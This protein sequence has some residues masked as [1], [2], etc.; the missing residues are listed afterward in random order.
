MRKN[1]GK[2]TYFYPL[3]VLIIG[4]YDKDGNPDAMNAAWGGIHD[5]DEIFICL[6]SDHKTTKNIHLKQEF[7]VSFADAKHV[8][9]AD[10][11]GMVSAN[12]VVD[13]VAKAKLHP[14]KSEF[15]DAPYFEEFPMSLDC[16][17]KRL[18]DDGTTTYLVADIINVAVDEKYLNNGK[19]ETSKL[20]L[21]AFDSVEGTY[22]K[23]G[24]KVG[25]AFKDGLKLK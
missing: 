13:K 24:E 1:F 4:T 3:P 22:I 23:L 6:S 18:D 14:Q 9:E 21:I 20:E 2:K 17:V 19:I 8:V 25:K 12:K 16:K 7:T 11:V 15:V 10:Y 5:T